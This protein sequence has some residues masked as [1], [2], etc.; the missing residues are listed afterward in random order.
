M[1]SSG[2]CIRGKLND[3]T[4]YGAICLD[5]CIKYVVRRELKFKTGDKDKGFISWDDLSKCVVDKSLVS[6]MTAQFPE[7]TSF[8]EACRQGIYTIRKS[9]GKRLSKI[10]HVRCFASVSNPIKLKKHTYLSQKE[11]KQYVYAQSGDLYTMVKYTCLSNKK[12][13]FMPYSLWDITQNRKELGCDVPSVIYMDNLE[14]KKE[15]RLVKNDM[16]LLYGK[17]ENPLELSDNEILSRIYVVR[18]FE[19]DRNRIIMVKN[20]CAKSDAELGKGESIKSWNE[21]PD[22][23]RCVI[24]TLNYLILGKDFIIDTKSNKVRFDVH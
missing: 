5:G 22:K 20:S 2:S 23:I 7:G 24:T 6:M 8:K 12:V 13:L 4:Y 17:E 10:R 18:G 14:Y 1:Y 3:T 21:L 15:Y 11:Y 9:D 16:L 19:K